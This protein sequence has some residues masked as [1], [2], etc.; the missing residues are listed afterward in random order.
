MVSPG[1]EARAR[2]SV[3]GAAC[4]ILD[5]SLQRGGARNPPDSIAAPPQEMHTPAI[6]WTFPASSPLRK[7]LVKCT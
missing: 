2:R 6:S 5:V 3:H 1:L 7:C 4:R